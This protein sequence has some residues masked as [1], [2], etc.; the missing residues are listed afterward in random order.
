M[1][2]ILAA[3]CVAL[4]CLVFFPASPVVSA[5]QGEM[6]MAENFTDACYFS[7]SGKTYDLRILTGEYQSNGTNGFTYELDP[8]EQL[9]IDETPCQKPDLHG[10]QYSWTTGASFIIGVQPLAAGALDGK[11]T[12]S[13][14][15]GDICTATGRPRELFITYRCG[16]ELGYPL[17]VSEVHCHYYFEWETSLLC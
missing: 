12:V 2:T 5:E 8:C 3:I 6:V 16:L 14:G 11:V 10:C 17:F 9:L 1:K 4:L 7:I 13:Y 15:G